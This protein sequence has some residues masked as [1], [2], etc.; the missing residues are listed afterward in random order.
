MIHNYS[1]KEISLILCTRQ[2]V[3]QCPNTKVVLSG[4]SQGAQLVHNAA[5]QISSA[6]ANRVTAGKSSFITWIFARQ[7]Y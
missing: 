4:Y 7:T 3:T 2:A 5:T 6:V 1:V